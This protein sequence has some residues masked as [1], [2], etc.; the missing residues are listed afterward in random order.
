M[1]A[2]CLNAELWE[3][4]ECSRGPP[5]PHRGRPPADAPDALARGCFSGFKGHGRRQLRRR[6]R[7]RLRQLDLP[8]LHTPGLRASFPGE[9][10]SGRGAGGGVGAA[11]KETRGCRSP[12]RSH[13]LP[14]PPPLPRLPR[15]LAL[16]PWAPR[17]SSRAHRT[18]AEAGRRVHIQYG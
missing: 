9:E 2:M 12:A 15:S 16:A 4:G 10:G 17:G 14:F 8:L 13:S 5:Q 6:G 3:M 18:Q 11:G 7:G 1:G